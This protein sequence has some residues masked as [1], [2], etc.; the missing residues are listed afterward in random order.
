MVDVAKL[1]EAVQECGCSHCRWL[2]EQ[3]ETKKKGKPKC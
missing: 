1:A 2:V 3:A